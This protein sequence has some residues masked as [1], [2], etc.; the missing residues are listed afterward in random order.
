MRIL[1][2][3]LKN[4]NSLKGEFL[5]DFRQPPFT[6]TSL[7]AI[8]G[9]TGAGKTTLL[10]A[11]CLALYHQTPR[12][13]VI[14]AASN[15]LMTR[16]TAEALAEVEFEVKGVGYR[17]FWSQ[18]R[19]REQAD[20]KL[21][22]PKVE[23][24]ELHSG[25]LLSTRI[26]EK[27][28]LTE[29][30]TGL[31]FERF[32]R[33]MLLAQG[34]FAAFLNAG[35]NERAELLEELTGTEI[36]GR[37]SA[38]VFEHTRI[39][40]QQLD[41]LQ[42][43]ASGVML[44]SDEQLEALQASRLQL[45]QQEQTLIPR[46]RQLQTALQ[47][48]RQV[49]DTQQRLAQLDQ[50]RTTLQQG[51][52]QQVHQGTLQLLLAQRVLEQETLWHQQQHEALEKAQ[53]DL[54]RE[55]QQCQ[56]DIRELLAEQTEAQLQQQQNDLTKR[57]GHLDALLDLE[58]VSQRQAVQ[59][60][61]LVE[62]SEAKTTGL[63]ELTQ[64]R[65]PLRDT[66]THIRD[67]VKD[68]EVLLRQE[69]RIKQ[70]EAHRQALQANEPCPLCGSR[71]H[72]AIEAYQALDVSAT[73][74][75]L[76]SLRDQ[77]ELVREQGSQLTAE[78]A[79]VQA[80]ADGLTRQIEALKTEQGNTASR[81]Q[82]FYQILVLEPQQE[83][84]KTL[85]TQL[86]SEQQSLQQRLDSLNKLKQQQH[87]I[88]QQLTR[89]Q[90]QQQAQY[91][92]DE[93]R[94]QQAQQ[95]QDLQQRF[96]ALAGADNPAVSDPE[97]RADQSLTQ[98]LAA[99]RSRLSQ[100]EQQ[101]SDLHQLEGQS[102]SL[103]ESLKTAL[104]QQSETQPEAVLQTEADQLADTLRQ[105]S[106]QLGQLQQQLKQD[107]QLRETLGALQLKIDQ[108]QQQCDRWQQ[109]NHLIGAKDGAKY[110][111]FAQGLTLDHLI[112]LANTQLERLHNR[113]QLARREAAELEIEVIDTWQADAR[114][115]TRTLSGGESF[116]VSLALALG[117]SDLV[118]HKT[119]IDSLFLDEGFG[120]LDAE[121]LEVALDALDN[122]NASGKTIGIISHVEALKERIPVQI[123]VSKQQGLG[124]SRL[125]VTG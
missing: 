111:R 113:F 30:L 112:S 53:T 27:L 64:Q 57:Q 32:T 14:S 7:F 52:Q 106:M 96:E 63:T 76:Q 47:L 3:R 35:A 34:G 49:H 28:Q 45:Q 97:V 91:Q 108:Q 114:R 61:Q 23:L 44:L 8:T 41:L 85:S 6:E 104:A 122:L 43:Q 21:Q 72:P 119:S 26:Q 48:M 1:S 54:Q 103:Q 15:E 13:K 78:I 17:A 95:L 4:L 120:T 89:Q 94:R 93:T 59:M 80:E 84:T 92:A 38:A 107:H 33:S 87:A 110:R 37:L 40:K 31:D 100:L 116:L 88:E 105:T 19:A 56:T 16:H 24:A 60:T 10:D 50:T 86:M 55:Q 123:R 102:L 99:I 2:L 124:N 67:Q 117:L 121:T 36:Y 22:A 75:A 70:L 82:H 69:E 109:L 74:A 25:K 20:G 115:D 77:L 65:Q 5:I 29:T 68:K 71:E 46:Q 125:Q 98:C 12:M 11:L 118:S 62:L 51:W 83:A 9:A 66:Y 79:K 18:R 39:E 42:S 101:R 81:L 90:Q 58:K 73:E